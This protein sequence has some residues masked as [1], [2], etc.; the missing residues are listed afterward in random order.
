MSCVCVWGGGGVRARLKIATQTAT[1][2][3]VHNGEIKQWF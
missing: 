2:C 3:I 1:P